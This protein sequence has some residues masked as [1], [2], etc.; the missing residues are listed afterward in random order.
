MHIGPARL[1]VASALIYTPKSRAE[2]SCRRAKTWQIYQVK[3]S[4]RFDIV[5]HWRDS[6]VIEVEAVRQPSFLRASL[7]FMTSALALAML[8][9]LL[10]QI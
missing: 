7:G 3:S 1:S 4:L 5:K 9:V 8:M 10:G 6:H 2:L